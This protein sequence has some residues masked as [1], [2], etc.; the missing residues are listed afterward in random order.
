MSIVH[1]KTQERVGP[2]AVGPDAFWQQVDRHFTGPMATRRDAASGTGRRRPADIQTARWRGLAMLALRENAGWPVDRIARAF[3]YS[4]GH[5]SRC[6]RQ[7][8]AELRDSL[9]AEPSLRR[10]DT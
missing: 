9:G 8:T 7:V 6:L 2:T 10:D 4:R 3:G 5:V 1:E